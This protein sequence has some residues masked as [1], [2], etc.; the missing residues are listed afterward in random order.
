MEMRD[1]IQVHSNNLT[2]E[3]CE[4]VIQKFE[5]D[6]RKRPGRVIGDSSNSE[7]CVQEEYKISTDLYITNLNDWKHEDRVFYDSLR[8]PLQ[9]YIKY[10]D[11]INSEMV[12]GLEDKLTDTGYQ[13]QRT[14]P[15][16]YYSWH[17]DWHFDIRNGY[18]LFT[19][20]WYLND[21][22]H[23]GETEFIDG[24]K[25]KPE[26]GKLL[27]FPAT[28]TYVHRGVSPLTETKYISTGWVYYNI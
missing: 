28:W 7:S 19:Y 11:S 16:E 17:H 9:D 2:P 3:F 20:I 22:H 8:Q 1:L 10:C 18:R 15:G 24:T 27:F 14:C 13:I 5:S 25:I 26:Q 12:V 6:E 4:H 21:I 23:E